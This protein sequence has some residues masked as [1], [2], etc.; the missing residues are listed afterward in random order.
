VVLG[1]GIV[2]GSGWMRPLELLRGLGKDGLD[3]TSASSVLLVD[4]DVAGCSETGL[5]GTAV[6]CTFVVP[7]GEVCCTGEPEFPKEVPMG[8]GRGSP[9]CCSALSRLLAV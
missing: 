9:A 8:P 7:L 3:R 5:G 6:V 4:F 2:V 1:I